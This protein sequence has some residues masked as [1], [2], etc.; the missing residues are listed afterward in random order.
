ME[1]EIGSKY[2]FT[3]NGGSILPSIITNAVVQSS[4]MSY[5]LASKVSAADLNTIH[6]NIYPNLSATVSKLAKDQRYIVIETES[7]NTMVLAKSWISG[8]PVIYRDTSYTLTLTG[9]TANEVQAIKDF[10]NY[11]N[12]S[13]T[14]Q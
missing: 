6:N 10:L 4:D 1:L 12:I 9:P 11:N 14:I 3:L 5:T 13:F 7:G 8:D 2:T